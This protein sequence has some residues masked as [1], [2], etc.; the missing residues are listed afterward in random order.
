MTVAVTI[1]LAGCVPVPGGGWAPDGAPDVAHGPRSPDPMDGSPPSSERGRGEA[2]SDP[3]AGDVTAPELLVVRPAGT[4]IGPGVPVVLRIDPGARLD[5]ALGAEPSERDGG[6]TSGRICAPRVI[7]GASDDLALRALAGAHAV[8]EG[9]PLVLVESAD[10]SSADALIGRLLRTGAEDVAS[11]GP[12]PPGLNASIPLTTD[13]V[14]PRVDLVALALALADLAHGSGTDRPGTGS[15]A[16][17]VLIAGSDRA[18]QA[19]VVAAAGRGAIPLV[20]PDEDELAASLVR[21]LLARDIGLQVLWAASSLDHERMLDG[22][23]GVTDLPRWTPSPHLGDVLELWLGDVRDPDA[24]LLAAVVSAARGGAF[25]AVDGDELRSG[26]GRTE[27]IRSASDHPDR[28]VT[29]VLVGRSTEH[30]AWQL[31]TVLMGTPLPGGGFLPLEDR[32]IVALYGSPDTPSLGMLGQ[33]DDAAT[34]DRAREVASRYRDAVDGRIVVP[35]LDVI[36]TIASSAA[37]PTG[38]F[39]RRVPIERLRRLVDAAGE[40]QMAVFL[41]LQPGRT[42]FL[43]QAQEL[44]ELLRE[45][46]VHLALDPEWRLGPGER[47]LVRIGSVGAEEVQQVADWLAALVR[48]ERLPQKVL[49]LHQF[50]LAMV[51]DRDDIVVPVEL[52]GVVHVDGQGRLATKDRTYAVLT[53]GAEERWAWGWKNFTRIDVPVATPEQSLARQ[54]VP[55]IVTYQ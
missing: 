2:C 12:P 31:D 19:D 3:R 10:A 26:A 33:Q 50:T 25:V 46:H 48:S 47:H 37:E 22:P 40:A 21:D 6:S 30:T 16:T 44:E 35:G 9:V 43:V 53:R 32:R 4:P 54:P 1:L 5:L 38:D 28:T 52:I 15:A 18:M 29:V 17:I 42:S 55:V 14:G 34:V 36:A 45:P 20:L 51:P 24:A 13:L 8:I 39:S 23:A 49:M 7:L 11:Y 41:D 27:R